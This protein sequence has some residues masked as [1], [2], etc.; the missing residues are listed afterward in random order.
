MARSR[1]AGTDLRL[2]KNLLPAT[3]ADGANRILP[4]I[5]PGEILAGEPEEIGFVGRADCQVI[6]VSTH[7]YEHPVVPP[8]VLHLRQ[9]P[10]RT[11]VKLP[12]SG[13]A[14]PS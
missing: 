7:P 5:R 9:V 10:F 13:Q 14:S 1:A 12:H 6:T 3:E 11:K 4:A 2:W 8:Q